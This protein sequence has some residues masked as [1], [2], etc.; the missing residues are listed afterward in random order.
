MRSANGFVTVL[1]VPDGNAPDSKQMVP[2]I[3][4][5]VRHTCVVPELVRADDGYASAAGR[6]DLRN[7]GVGS[8]RIS[9]AKGKKL[10]STEDWQS[11]IYSNARRCRSAVES[12]M[13]TIKDGLFLAQFRTV[14]TPPVQ[15]PFRMGSSFESISELCIVKF[16]KCLLTKTATI[17]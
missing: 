5:S 1:I 10:I 2:A 13:F 6:D 8:I 15:K 16:D 11:E 14:E 17:D 12:L 3:A 9:G 7:L 4:D